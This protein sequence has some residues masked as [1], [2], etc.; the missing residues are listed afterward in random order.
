MDEPARGGAR[1][2]SYF[3]SSVVRDA[4]LK[5]SVKDIEIGPRNTK[6]KT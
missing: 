6:V 1:T 5:K 4:D 2:I 3:D